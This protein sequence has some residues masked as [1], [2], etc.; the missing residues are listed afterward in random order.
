MDQYTKSKGS[1]T[2]TGLSGRTYSTGGGGCSAGTSLVG[3]LYTRVNSGS[4]TGYRNPNWKQKIRSVTHATTPAS[5]S[6]QEYIASPSSGTNQFWT[7]GS[8]SGH[9]CTAHGGCEYF[10]RCVINRYTPDSY[11][12]YSGVV[13]WPSFPSQTTAENQATSKLYDAIIEIQTSLQA[14]EDLGEIRQTANMLRSPMRSLRNL[15]VS[16]LEGHQRGLG[17][18]RASHAAKALAD[19]TLEYRFGIKPLASSIANA[20]TGLQNRDEAF[21]YHPF[22]VTGVVRNQNSGTVSIGVGHFSTSQVITRFRERR[23]RY[24][25]VWGYKVPIHRRSVD[26][27]LGLQWR[28]VVP[29]IWNLIPY[30]WLADYVTNIG[31]FA[32]RFAV[33]WSGTRWCNKTVRT[34]SEF[35]SKW[36]DNTSLSGKHGYTGSLSPGSLTWHDTSFTRS[37]QYSLP[38]P[39][40]EIDLDLSGNQLVNIGALMVSRIPILGSMT[41]RALNRS[42]SLQSAFADEIG[43]RKE[44]IPY[45]FHK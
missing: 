36:T 20:L 6:L 26:Q 19:T 5:G 13:P 15:M 7:S 28:H 24:R 43:R 27:V 23:V 32:N 31:D 16:T 25:G 3:N 11:E 12:H 9:S 39:I 30:S 42:P 45:P 38:N 34:R 33:D 37:P 14:G 8:H 41:K 40:F 18:K 21:H 44:R 29:T 35:S 22:D 1:T 17:I 2:V 10:R 4:F